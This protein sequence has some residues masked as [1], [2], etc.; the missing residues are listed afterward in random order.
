MSW[1]DNKGGDGGGP[2]GSGGGNNGQN[3][4]GNRPQGG[5]GQEPPDL[6][7][8]VR[9]MQ[10]NLRGIFGGG[11]GKGSDGSG[12]SGGGVFG[13]G[14]VLVIIGLV[15][16]GMPGSGWYVVDGREVGLV[17]QFG[18][19]KRTT[20]PGLHFK[21]PSPIETVEIVEA[22]ENQTVE[23]GFRG[24][25]NVPQESLMLT[26][27]E[28]IADVHFTV[29]WR[30]D[31]PNTEQFDQ[32]VR[33]FQFNIID[34]EVT[35]RAIAESAMR[36]VVGST[37]LEPL[38][39]TARA[40]V[41]ERARLLMQLTLDEYGSGIRVLEVQLEKADPPAEV[42]EAFNAVVAANQEAQQRVFDATAYANRL[43]P[44]ARGDATRRIRQAEGYRDSVIAEAQGEAD[45]FEA[46]LDEY[47]LAPEVTRRRMY[48]ETMERV[49]SNSE[50]IILDGEAGAVPYLPLDQLRGT[51]RNTTQGDR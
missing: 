26:R 32:G 23:V 10:R 39:T 50:L 47:L 19:F 31:W 48:L 42:I 1:N 43:I 9:Q 45:R 5:G 17:L 21:L 41:V 49:L 30:V 8:L 14:L 11:G 27:D 15:W 37:N 44:E 3:P 13:F 2:W 51:T 25:R 7:E 22:T 28:N 33:N 4:W 34:H 12:G 38:Q 29:Q 36:E 46:I 16:I 35:V 6:D 20:Q 18:E 24:P 40:E